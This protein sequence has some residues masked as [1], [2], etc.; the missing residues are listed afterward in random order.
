MLRNPDFLSRS[1]IL[2]FWLRSATGW[3]TLANSFPYLGSNS[4]SSTSGY[5]TSGPI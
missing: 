5:V 2:C 4:D 1:E 3:P